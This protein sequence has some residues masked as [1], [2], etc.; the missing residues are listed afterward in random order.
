MKD[1]DEDWGWI[2]T[3][4]LH[5]SEYQLQII[6]SSTRQGEGGV[7][8][9]HNREYQT[10]RIEISPLVDT[11]EY[12]AW[13]ITVRNRNITLLGIYYQPIGSTSGN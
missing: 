11:I 9:L 8:L 3:S 7:A 1:I 12:G 2:A 5:N 4:A 6:N 10:T 13:T